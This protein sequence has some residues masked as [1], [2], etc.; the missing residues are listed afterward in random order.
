[1]QGKVAKR[2]GQGG[3]IHSGPAGGSTEHSGPRET[4]RYEHVPKDVQ[5]R[6]C[7][8]GG[9]AGTANP[10]SSADPDLPSLWEAWM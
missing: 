2:Q 9:E 8:G 4:P 5:M 7:G 1:M 3:H 10:P 6:G